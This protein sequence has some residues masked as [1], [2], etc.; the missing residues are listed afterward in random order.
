MSTIDEIIKRVKNLSSVQQT[1][2]LEILRSWQSGKQRT[3]QRDCNPIDIDVLIGDKL[4]QTDTKN[5]SASG[6]FIKT[7]SKVDIQENVKVVFSVPGAEKPFKLEGRI[8]RAEPG[9][10]AV[11][12]SNMTPYFQQVLDDAI[13]C[14]E[15]ISGQNF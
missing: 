7:A 10:I 3:F 14:I 13:W 8:V 15:K 1:E 4:I 9:G 5:I 6:V 12:F 2:I 11:E